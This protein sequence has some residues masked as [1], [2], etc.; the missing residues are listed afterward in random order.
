MLK[1]INMYV[2]LFYMDS[3]TACICRK[4]VFEQSIVLMSCPLLPVKPAFHQRGI[5]E[6][7][8]QS[9]A[10]VVLFNKYF[11]VLRV[12]WHP[13]QVLKCRKVKQGQSGFSACL[14]EREAY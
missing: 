13:Y 12:H 6:S 7:Y 8:S 10:S 3:L 11:H 5:G 9:L 1:D 14:R 4:F 2:L